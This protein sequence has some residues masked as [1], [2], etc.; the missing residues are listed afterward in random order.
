MKRYCI[1]SKIIYIC[2][3]RQASCDMNV[4]EQENVTL[5][6]VKVAKEALQKGSKS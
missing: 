6:I 4:L 1:A 5:T 2:F 3:Q